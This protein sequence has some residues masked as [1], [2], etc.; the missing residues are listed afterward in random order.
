MNRIASLFPMEDD[1]GSSAPL[2]ES[3]RAN[4]DLK[5]IQFMTQTLQDCY[6]VG[7][8]YEDIFCGSEPL[9]PRLIEPVDPELEKILLKLFGGPPVC[10]DEPANPVACDPVSQSQHLVQWSEILRQKMKASDFEVQPNGTYWCRAQELLIEV[11]RITTTRFS[12]D[13]HSGWSSLCQRHRESAKLYTRQGMTFRSAWLLLRNV[14]F[15]CCPIWI[16]LELTRL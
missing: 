9:A 13:C 1:L 4:I 5:Q 14:R 12:A 6:A 2:P 11:S 3:P 8:S 15:C 10:L 7:K 16:Q